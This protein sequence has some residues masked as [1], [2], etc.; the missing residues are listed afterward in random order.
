M[1]AVG[2]AGDAVGLPGQR[3]G[4]IVEV[5]VLL[6]QV[7]IDIT[8]APITTTNAVICIAASGVGNLDGFNKAFFDAV[9]HQIHKRIVVD[10]PAVHAA[11]NRDGLA[12]GARIGARG[13]DGIAIAGKL[14]DPRSHGFLIKHGLHVFVNGDPLRDKIG[15]DFRSS[16]LAHGQH[17][18]G[19]DHGVGLLSGGF[20][21]GVGGKHRRLQQLLG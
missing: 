2:D 8:V 7:D 18:I 21:T 20:Q 1:R 12:I 4:V 13:A 3:T 19:P 14:V 11:G 5:N 15:I 10:R 9:D 16:R 6:R 17:D